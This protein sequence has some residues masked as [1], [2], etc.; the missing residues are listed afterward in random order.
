M[1]NPNTFAET[2]IVA[3]DP[4]SLEKN[5]QVQTAFCVPNVH[6][7]DN[8]YIRFSLFQAELTNFSIF[9]YQ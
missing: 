5:Q 1:K 2:S 4:G 3:M 8:T 7:K 6:D 9:V